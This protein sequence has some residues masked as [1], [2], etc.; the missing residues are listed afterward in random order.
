VRVPVQRRS[1]T[2]WTMSGTSCSARLPSGFM[3]RISS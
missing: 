1:W 2:N 3:E